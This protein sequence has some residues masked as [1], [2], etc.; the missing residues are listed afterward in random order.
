MKTK[1][2]NT[3]KIKGS[4]NVQKGKLKKLFA[5]L[6]DNDFVYKNG[7]QNEMFLKLQIKLGKTKRELHRIISAL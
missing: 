6:T 5:R 7:Q 1:N 4:W 3:T 2:L